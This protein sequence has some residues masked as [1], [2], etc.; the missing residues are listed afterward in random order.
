MLLDVLIY[1][2]FCSLHWGQKPHSKNDIKRVVRRALYCTNR[3]VQFKI[4]YT[5]ILIHTRNNLLTNNKVQF[6][7]HYTLLLINT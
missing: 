7:I 4:Q 2:I 6:K 5:L 1:V 3:K